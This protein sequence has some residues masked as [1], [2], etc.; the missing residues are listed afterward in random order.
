MTQTHHD[1]DTRTNRRRLLGIGA[2]GTALGIG[3]A[4]AHAAAPTRTRVQ[5]R[6]TTDFAVPVQTMAIVPWTETVFRTGTDVT[7]QADG[8]LLIN[9][10]G[11]YEIVFSSDWDAKSGND[12]DLR[13]IGIRHQKLGQPDLP[14]E[15]HDRLGFLNIPGS[16]PGAI[17]RY[18]GNWAPAP[19]PLMGMSS[20]DVS[21]SPAGT[22]V[23]GDVA[24]ASLTSINQNQLSDQALSALSV[25]AKVI[26]P[27]IVRVT[28]FNPAIQDGITV[29]PGH[30][31]VAAMS[32]TKTRGSNGD[33]WMVLHTASV[34]L[35]AG[36]RVYGLIEHKVAGTLLQ[37]T[38]SSFMQ[39][40]RVA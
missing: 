24:Q 31:Q 23:P 40:D 8:K 6:L 2:A 21:V 18:Q 5:F 35:N 4:P 1:A 17:A 16:D 32:M 26:A 36:D 39:V 10:T 14:L 28:L 34:A 11:V 20:V 30:L 3:S 29:A 22:V 37:A 12:I 38:R 27:N 25:Q 19:L 15:D 33:A 13:K 9:R 7:L